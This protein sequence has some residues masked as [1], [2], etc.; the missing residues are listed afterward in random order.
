MF[1]EVV[2]QGRGGSEVK[3]MQTGRGFSKEIIFYDP[4][5]TSKLVTLDVQIWPRDMFYLAR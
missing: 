5:L 2:S 1:R 3:S 4:P